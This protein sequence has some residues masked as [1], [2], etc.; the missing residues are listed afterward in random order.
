MNQALDPESADLA[1][2]LQHGKKLLGKLS[3]LLFFLNCG[4]EAG[5]DRRDF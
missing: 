1:V 4:E 5:E 2:Y 3:N